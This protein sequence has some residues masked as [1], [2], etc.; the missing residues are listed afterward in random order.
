MLGQIENKKM[1][2]S[3]FGKIVETE[4]L[5]SFDI[6][7]ELILD[8]FVIMP[9]HLHAIVILK[10]N[11]L[12]VEPHGRAVQQLGRSVQQQGPYLYRRPKSISSFIAGFKSAVNSKIDDFIDQNHLDIPKYDRNNRF[13]QSNYF[14]HIIRNQNEYLRIWNYIIDNP[15]NWKGV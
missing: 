3:D 4:W 6:R 5:K 9:N 12:A 2:L 1:V 15:K 7:E 10:N 14:D 13:F 11:G 8:E